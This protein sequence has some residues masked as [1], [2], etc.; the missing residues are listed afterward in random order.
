MFKAVVFVFLLLL[1]HIFLL[2]SAIIMVVFS[3]LFENYVFCLLRKHWLRY[4]TLKCS[5]S[6][7]IYAKHFDFDIKTRYGVTTK[8][9]PLIRPR[10]FCHKLLSYLVK[11][12]LC[13]FYPDIVIFFCSDLFFDIFFLL[14][15]KGWVP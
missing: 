9:Y 4:K 13:V 5:P 14:M 6:Y 3:T 1:S 8:R 12:H 10:C 7:R 15:L 2:I 11:Q